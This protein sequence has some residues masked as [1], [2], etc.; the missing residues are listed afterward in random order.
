MTGLDAQSVPWG[1]YY[2][3]TP[4]Y[5]VMISE[6]LGSAANFHAFSDLAPAIQTRPQE[7][8]IRM[9]VLTTNAIAK[10]TV[11]RLRLRSTSDPPPSGPAPVPTPK[12]VPPSE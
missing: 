2:E 12:A 3:A 6:A 5:D 1:I 8:L 10:P 11:Q 7:I 4:G 9:M